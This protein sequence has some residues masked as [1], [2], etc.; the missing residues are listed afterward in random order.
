MTTMRLL[1]STL[2]ALLA[3]AA[4]AVA[5][6][7]LDSNLTVGSETASGGAGGS[8]LPVNTGTAGTGGGVGGGGPGGGGSGGTSPDAG[9]TGGMVGMPEPVQ[10][11]EPFPAINLCAPDVVDEEAV[12]ITCP[13]E[14][15][16]IAD[17]LPFTPPMEAGG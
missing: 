15:G 2:F 1:D 10:P 5:C 3:A 11:L 17:W 14:I 12:G 13:R 4:L 8:T 6:Q 7:K 9:A 16:D